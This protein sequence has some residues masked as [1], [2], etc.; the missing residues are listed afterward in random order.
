M[1][2]SIR[3]MKKPAQ[4]KMDAQAEALFETYSGKSETELME[5]LKSMTAEERSQL[6]A[7]EQELAPMLSA[8]QRQKLAAIIRS[9]TN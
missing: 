9:L 6:S 4:P 5:A 1:S 8:T 3:D 2:R 7:L